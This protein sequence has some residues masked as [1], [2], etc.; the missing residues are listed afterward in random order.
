MQI[1]TYI[2]LD[3]SVAGHVQEPLIFLNEGR[4]II[5]YNAN[6]IT[7]VISPTIRQQYGNNTIY[8]SVPIQEWLPTID[9][10]S[11]RM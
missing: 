5:D 2:S 8:E 10:Y 9:H 3:H 11:L 4:T 1:S 6:I 7:R